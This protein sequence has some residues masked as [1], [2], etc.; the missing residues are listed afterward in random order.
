MSD[1]PM[2]TTTGRRMTGQL[3]EALDNVTGRDRALMVAALQT[4]EGRT[5]PLLRALALELNLAGLREHEAIT[6]A[7]ADLAVVDD[8]PWPQPPDGPA[9][10]FD[11]A[12]GNV[13]PTPPDGPVAA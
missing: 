9:M 2:F 4:S 7:E 5:G 10:W 3:Q 6:A 12:T 1:E 8:R 11:P 13:S